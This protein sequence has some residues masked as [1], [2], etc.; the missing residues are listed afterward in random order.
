MIFLLKY[1]RKDLISV[2]EPSEYTLL[3]VLLQKLLTLVGQASFRVQ[4]IR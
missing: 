2:I 3:S 4:M 1:V